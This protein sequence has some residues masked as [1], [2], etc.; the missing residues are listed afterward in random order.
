MSATLSKDGE[1]AI[2][3]GASV[4]VAVLCAC[5]AWWAASQEAAAYERA[6]GKRVSTWD[7]L[8]LE[9]R[10]EGSPK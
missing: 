8:F 6:T 9:L 10:V 5:F 7:A 4:L 3:C 1:V 2:G